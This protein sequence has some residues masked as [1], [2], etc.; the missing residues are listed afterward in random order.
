MVALL[1]TDGAGTTTTIDMV[2]ELVRPDASSVAVLGTS[3]HHAIA[4]GRVAVVMQT[5]GLLKAL[6][7]GDTVEL[8]TDLFTDTGPVPEVLERAGL[9]GSPA[10]VSAGAPGESSSGSGSP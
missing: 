6:T 4:E 1:G 5:G 7:V 9:T 3:P 2:L 8:T 10:G